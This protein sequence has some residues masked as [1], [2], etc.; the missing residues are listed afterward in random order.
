MAAR[1]R[2]ESQAKIGEDDAARAVAL[3]QHDIAGLEVAVDDS[4]SVDGIETPANL[5]CDGLGIARRMG[6]IATE[7]IGKGYA[8]QKLHG[9]EERGQAWN[10]QGPGS[11]PLDGEE[12]M[13]AADVGVAYAASEVHFLP[14]TVQQTR[15]TGDFAANG[16]E[17]NAAQFQIL[18]LIDLA[19][20]AA[21]KQPE[22]AEAMEQ[23]LAVGENGSERGG[24]P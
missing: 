10:N 14:E 4:S 9:E 24:L 8:L 13:D 17:G 16:L 18:R 3:D 22:N 1:A 12:F 20:A 19:H 11:C 2:L 7:L 21:A 6:A 23:D 5:V 15:V